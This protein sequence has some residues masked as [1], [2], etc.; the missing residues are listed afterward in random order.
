MPALARGS[1]RVGER[2]EPEEQQR[3]RQAVCR[4]P[5]ASAAARCRRPARPRRPRLS[6]P[7]ASEIVAAP[8]SASS[9]RPPSQRRAADRQ[10]EQRLESLV[11]FLVARG[12]DLRADEQAD[13]EDEEDEHER[14]VAG[15]A[16]RSS[17]SRAWRSRAGCSSRCPA[18]EMLV[19]TMPRMNAN[20]PTL[21]SQTTRLPRS[22]R[23]ACAVGEESSRRRGCALS[24]AGSTPVPM[25]R[26]G[27]D[28]RRRRRAAARLAATGSSSTSGCAPVNGRSSSA[29]PSGV[30]PAQPASA[31]RGVGD[32]AQQQRQATTAR[33][34]LERDAACR[35]ELAG[36]ARR[37][38]R[39]PARPT[40]VASAR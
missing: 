21:R 28:P 24:R 30:S 11:G 5:R 17:R 25:S 37:R 15:R 1:E 26:R 4:R 32:H 22:L 40:T 6:S 7:A 38:R 16:S 8:A 35:R 31:A 14:E 33:A 13:G 29:Q 27:R 36:A 19:E 10:R 18:E 23:S 34:E 39:T 3:D 9:S 20:A 2:G 12:A